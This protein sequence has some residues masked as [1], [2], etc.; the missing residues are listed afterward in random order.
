LLLALMIP[1][2][3]LLLPQFLL[4]R[5]LGLIDSLTGLVVFYVA[6]SLALNTFLLRGFMEDQPHDLDEAMV[7][8]GASPLTRYLRL[9][10]PLAR[11]ALAAVAIFTFIGSWEEFVLALTLNNSPE[12]WTLP[13]GIAQFQGQH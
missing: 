11:P 4:A 13:V 7:V 2:M 8:D 9:A 6:G 10:L 12:T 1:G 3:M 5:R